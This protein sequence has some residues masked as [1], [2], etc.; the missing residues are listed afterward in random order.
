[1]KSTLSIIVLTHNDEVRIVDCL[2]NLGFAEE[3]IVVDDNSNDRT[4]DLVRNYT[5]QIYVR[6][7][8]KNFSN[9]RNFALN[10]AHGEWVLFVDSDEIIT[11]KLK[12]EILECI[13]IGSVNGYFIKRIDYIWGE[14]ILHGEA[15]EVVLLRL[16][17]KNSGKWHGKVHETWNVKGSTGRLKNPLFHVPHQNVSEFLADIDNYSSLRAEELKEKGSTV[18]AMQIIAYPF[19]KF[20]QNY[21]FKLGYQDGIPG[22]IYAVLMSFHSF[23]VRAKLYQLQNK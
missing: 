12:K 21:I 11:D 14:K 1:M 19:A 10:K 3:L 9:Q 6:G 15:G 20:I 17:K 8:D 13:K 7:L 2:E 5:N 4:V 22:F 18:S 23:L 16:A